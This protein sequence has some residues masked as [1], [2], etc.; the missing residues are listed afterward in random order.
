M[1]SPNDFIDIAV[2]NDFTF[3]TGVPCSFLTPLLNNVINRKNIK[4]VGATSEGEAVAISTGA[5][6]AGKKSVVMCQNSGLGNM[7]N[8]LTSLSYPFRIPLLLLISW[9][10]EPG[11]M[12][13]P[14]HELMGS[15]T[16]S[17]LEQL[18][19]NY[20][21][22]PSHQDEL[23]RQFDRAV[24]Y[25]LSKGVSSSFIL[26]R[27]TFND[28][29]LQLNEKL[30]LYKKGVSHDVRSMHVKTSR[31][32]CLEA[33]ALILPQN[34]PVVTTTGKTGR[35]LF[36][37]NDGPQNLYQVGSMGCASAMGLGIALNYI[38]NVIVVDGDGAALMKLGNMATIGAQA[39]KNL[40]H[41]LLDNSV[42]DSTGEQPTVSQ[43][44]DFP[45]IAISC[46]YNNVWLCDDVQ[47]LTLA[48]NNC[49]Q[50]NGPNFIHMRIKP[51]SI[52]QL[53]RPNITPQDVAIRFKDFLASHN[54]N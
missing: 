16:L 40:I 20:C 45:G 18:R 8:P 39:P 42:H 3:Y 9:R 6:L 34:V 53:G 17:L 48:I 47:G 35:E 32:S 25:M 37:I 29:E 22:T 43:S 50:D 1:I 10:G 11:V 51:G 5:W 27:K 33:L 7:I 49:L 2:L 23:F 15:I 38:N 46:G 52:K 21:L 28:E 12:D 4:Y 36:T 44:I 24:N 19:I 13:E 26:T 54:M 31:I 41:I 30:C 14:Q